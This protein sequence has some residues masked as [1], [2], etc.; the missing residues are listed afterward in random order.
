[1]LEGLPDPDMLPTKLFVSKWPEHIDRPPPEG[2][3]E[4]LRH[5]YKKK[6]LK[7]RKL[8]QKVNGRNSRRLKTIDHS[9]TSTLLRDESKRRCNNNYVK[10]FGVEGLEIDKPLPVIHTASL[11]PKSSMAER[12]TS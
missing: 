8:A 7:D 4:I 6:Y 3:N 9:N 5:Q 11:D 12:L 2:F 10:L 1:M